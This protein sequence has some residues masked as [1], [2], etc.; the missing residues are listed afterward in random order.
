MNREKER[1]RFWHMLFNFDTDQWPSTN[2]TEFAKKEASRQVQWSPVYMGG[3]KIHGF[4]FCARVMCVCVII[5][6]P[7]QNVS[8]IWQLHE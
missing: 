2:S 3:G 8:S 7:N 1:N 6:D 4:M 5:F